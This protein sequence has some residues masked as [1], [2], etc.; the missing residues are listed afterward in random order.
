MLSVRARPTSDVKLQQVEEYVG[1]DDEGSVEVRG[2]SIYSRDRT[3]S[4]KARS[5]R[6]CLIASQYSAEPVL[7]KEHLSQSNSL[8]HFCFSLIF[9]VVFVGVNA[10]GSSRR[11]AG[12]NV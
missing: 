11:L 1:E 12:V 5:R 8:A 9:F 6:Y 3:M 4:A 10:V 2:V 7:S